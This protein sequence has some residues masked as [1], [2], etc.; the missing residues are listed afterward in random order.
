MKILHWLLCVSL[1]LYLDGDLSAQQ[2][3]TD[4]TGTLLNI[5]AVHLNR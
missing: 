3:I 2:H 4:P 1:Y 5:S